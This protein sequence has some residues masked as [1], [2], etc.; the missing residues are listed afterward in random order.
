MFKDWR[1]RRHCLCQP[2]LLK[3]VS[4]KRKSSQRHRPD[5]IRLQSRLQKSRQ[6]LACVVVEA[7]RLRGLTAMP[8]GITGGTGALEVLVLQRSSSQRTHRPPL[9]YDWSLSLA[10]LYSSL[11]KL[12]YKPTEIPRDV[13]RERERETHKERHEMEE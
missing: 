13:E 10:D 7:K 4:L 11:L 12:L 1:L 5:S 8:T 3:L 2:K 6:C 9:C